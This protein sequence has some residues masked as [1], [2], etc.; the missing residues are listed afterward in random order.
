MW[1][2][3]STVNFYLWNEGYTNASKIPLLTKYSTDK[4]KS[5]WKLIG[6]TS[7][8]LYPTLQNNTACTALVIF[9]RDIAYFIQIPCNETVIT[10][11]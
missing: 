5:V 6:A 7:S 2:D 4:F 9:S 10:D 3:N 1:T 11:K 8:N